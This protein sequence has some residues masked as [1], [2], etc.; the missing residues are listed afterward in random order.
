[1]YRIYCDDLLLYHPI[2]NDYK[3]LSGSVNLEL[4]TAGSMTFTLPET[5]NHYGLPKLMKSIITLKDDNR[6]IFRGRPYAPN[7]NLFKDNELTCDGELA[8][9]NDTI[10][11]PFSYTGTVEG[12]F[13]QVIE[14]HNAQVDASRRFIVGNVTVKND[15]ST[16]AIVR[17]DIEYQTTWNTL[18]EKFFESALGG[19][20]WIRHE[21]D[22]NYIDYLEDFD[23]LSL[24]NV[25]QSINLVDVKE[26]VS[27]DD[28]ATA[29]IP[30]GAKTDDIY[31][32]ISSVNNG[33][34]YLADEKAVKEYGYIFK[35]VRHDDITEVNNLYRAGVA[36]LAEAIGVVTTVELTA[37]DLSKA[38]YD[39][40]SFQF[41]TYVPIKIKRLDIDR[42]MLIKKMSFDLLRPEST[43]I[44]VGDSVKSLTKNF[45]TLVNGIGKIENNVVGVI[46]GEYDSKLEDHTSQITE[47]VTEFSTIIEQTE[48]MILN[49]VA[50]TYYTKDDTNTLFGQVSTEF[51]QT[52]EDFEMTFTELVT[53]ITNV[54]GT[55]NANYNEL[56]QFIRFNDG[57]I[58]LGEVG[59]PMKVTLTN[60]RLSFLQ[61][62]V[63]VAYVSDSKLYIYDGEF[64]NSLKIGRWVFMPRTNGNLSFTYI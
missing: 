56:V 19:Y 33:K 3:I 1:M 58:T 57:S 10:I 17:S 22:G 59:N 48:D 8:F 51:V 53:Q 46:R 40:N 9:F 37:S 38:G 29:V 63:E 34:K 18:K 21:E 15:T 16:E 12:L 39:V 43:N 55:V 50:E 5:N 54:D 25:E 45:G 13:R 6:V 60:D 27:S 32:D 47:I 52:K 42:N 30:L 62:D 44:T 35:V 31:L 36:D 7:R 41:G 49:A 24:Q 64:I 28:M 14:S 11:E 26:S 20:L 23:S 4:N 2:M 61:D